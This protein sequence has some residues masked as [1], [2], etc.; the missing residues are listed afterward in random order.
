VKVVKNKVAPPF[1][2]A[3]FDIICGVRG[4]SW[5]GPGRA[6]VMKNAPKIAERLHLTL[7]FLGRDQRLGRRLAR[8]LVGP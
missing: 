6:N 5:E 2:Q 4:I 7:D 1:K 8:G 3:E